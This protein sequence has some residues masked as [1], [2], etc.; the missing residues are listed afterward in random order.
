M[1][2]VKMQW[3]ILRTVHKPCLINTGTTWVGGAVGVWRWAGVPTWGNWGLAFI[4]FPSPAC[5]TQG[6][7]TWEGALVYDPAH[8]PSSL[9]TP[10]SLKV[11]SMEEGG[12]PLCHTTR[13]QGRRHTWAVTR[14]RTPGVED[15]AVILSVRLAKCK[16][17]KWEKKEVKWF[18]WSLVA[19][20]T[21]QAPG[22]WP[23]AGTAI[24]RLHPCLSHTYHVLG[25]C[26]H[27]QR[28]LGSELQKLNSGR[29]P[30]DTHQENYL[31][32]LC[33]Q[34]WAKILRQEFFIDDWSSHFNI[35]ISQ[36][37]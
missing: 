20:A 12:I 18:D 29:Q 3:K 2:T 32:A 26:S 10:G 5:A 34:I 22:G 35:P 13:P 37:N 23:G 28:G 19:G 21:C 4:P 11:T 27:R 16:E 36:R 1:V 8:P 33:L 24:P 6:E 14:T 9:P 7:F 15:I 30:Q 17:V 31:S 25:P